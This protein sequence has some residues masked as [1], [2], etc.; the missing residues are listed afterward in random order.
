[1]IRRAFLLTFGMSLAVAGPARAGFS[2]SDAGAGAASFLRL[3][4]G[5]R[6]SAMGETGAAFAEGA[7][8]MYWNPANLGVMRDRHIL[9]SHN[10]YVES[11]AHSFAAMQ[12]PRPHGDGLGL[13]VNYFSAGSIPQ[14][15][16]AGAQVGSFSPRDMAFSGGYALEVGRARLGIAGK[17]VSSRIIQSA[18]TFSVDAGISAAFFGGQTRLGAVGQNLS[19][20]LKFNGESEEIGKTVRAAVAQQ[21]GR[22]LLLSVEGVTGTGLPVMPA[23]GLELSLKGPSKSRVQLRSGY[24]AALARDKTDLAGFTAGLGF[25]FG[26]FNLDYVWVPLGDLGQTHRFSLSL[27]LLN[28]I[29][30]PAASATTGTER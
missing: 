9:L 4:A 15:D 19:G 5:A 25:G 2:D 16:E 3:A 24:S 18:S 1:M 27:R 11:T 29:K 7:D 22:R 8:A 20:A 23:V 14:I 21:L 30:P 26:G 13:S 28:P 12:F 6:E 17:Y 10:V